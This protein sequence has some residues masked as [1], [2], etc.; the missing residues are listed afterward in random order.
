MKTTRVAASRA[1]AISCLR[2]TPISAPCCR[3]THATIG[4]RSIRPSA[5]L[6]RTTMRQ[7]PTA[8]RGSKSAIATPRLIAL[9]I[10]TNSTSPMA[11]PSEP[12][13]ISIQPPTLT[14]HVLSLFTAATGSAIH[15]NCLPALPKVLPLQ[16]GPSPSP[17]IRSLRKQPCAASCGNRTGAG[18]AGG[19]RSG[20]RHRRAAGHC[21]MVGGRP[22]R[23][24]SS[25]APAHP[26]RTRH[27]GDLRA[28]TPRDT[29]LNQ[30]LNLTDDDVAE[31]SPLRR[32]IA[33]RPLTAARW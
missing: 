12:P 11:R 27:I 21:R 8:R 10:Q 24:A 29:N 1:N 26:G 15:A 31:F 16:D 33:G 17:I 23:G 2:P 32:D 14:R 9:H 13:S 19:S 30:A 7:L 25:F 22:A 5:T 20:A 3:R 4:P 28:R 6:P 18:L